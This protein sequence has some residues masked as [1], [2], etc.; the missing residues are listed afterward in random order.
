MVGMIVLLCF[1]ASQVCLGFQDDSRKAAWGL[2]PQ[3]FPSH[4]RKSGRTLIFLPLPARNCKARGDMGKSV[5]ILHGPFCCTALVFF[6]SCSRNIEESQWGAAPDSP[7]FY[8]YKRLCFKRS[9]N[10]LKTQDCV[11]ASCCA[12]QC[13]WWQGRTQTAH[14]DFLPFPPCEVSEEM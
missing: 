7:F 3:A 5:L 6:Y 1:P 9:Q 11:L 8:L 13:S 10:I 4:S 14:R 12:I 2:F